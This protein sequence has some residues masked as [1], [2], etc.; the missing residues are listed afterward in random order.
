M[1]LCKEQTHVHGNRPRPTGENRHLAQTIA[2][3]RA[4][5]QGRRCVRQTLT[6]RRENTE[7]TSLVGVKSQA[8]GTVGGS[9]SGARGKAGEGQGAPRDVI[10]DK[11]KQSQSHAVGGPDGVLAP[12]AQ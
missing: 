4:D 3:P 10:H 2:G 9:E 11:G 1:S 8:A 7:K 6:H 5:S 12:R